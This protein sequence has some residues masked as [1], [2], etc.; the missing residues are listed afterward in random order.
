MRSAREP[1]ADTFTLGYAGSFQAGTEIG[2]MF[3]AI[4]DLVRSGLDGRAVRF[5]MVGPFLPHQLEV[6]RERI[7]ADGSDGPAVHAPP[8][9]AARDGRMGW[10]VRDR[11]RRSAPAWQASCTNAWPFDG[12]SWSSRQRV[13]RRDWCAS[14][15]RAPSAIQAMPRA[16]ARRLRARSACRPRFAGASDEALA[17][18]DRRHQAERWSQLLHGLIDAAPRGRAG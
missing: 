18:F 9:R 10:P 3:T 2:P 17:P 11:N 8:R 12:R 5:E 16:F 6:A 1:T 15:T 13:P 7:P 14:S 4:G